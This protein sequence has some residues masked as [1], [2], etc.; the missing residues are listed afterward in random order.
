MA[1]NRMCFH[2]WKMTPVGSLTA[3]I[4]GLPWQLL[5]LHDAEI[6]TSRWRALCEAFDRAGMASD[7][8]HSYDV[9]LIE[10]GEDWEVYRR[11]WSR[12]HRQ[13]MS[14]AA[15]RLA[16]QGDLHHRV[17]AELLVPLLPR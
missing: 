9:A 4:G 11:C 2:L 3:A 12:K 8:R 1:T 13:K 5:R 6:A 14:W 16:Q 17:L 15:R 7:V 10:V